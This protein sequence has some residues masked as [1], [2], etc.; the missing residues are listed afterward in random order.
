MRGEIG[1]NPVMRRRALGARG[2]NANGVVSH[3]GGGFLFA[4]NSLAGLTWAASSGCERVEVDVQ[5]TGD[6]T[7]ED[8]SGD[9]TA[10]DINGTFLVNL[11]GSGSIDVRNVSRDVIV[12]RDG[13]GSIEVADVKG[14][15]RVAS[16]GSGG[17]SH[18]GVA[19]NVNV[20]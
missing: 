10:R 11:D 2:G 4:P 9:I 18:H 13:S 14:D 1:T 17:V 3:A 8:G 20:R 19:G 15:F 6:L 7:I 5:R 12:E 16:D